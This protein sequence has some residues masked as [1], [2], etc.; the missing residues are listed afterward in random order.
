ML[1]L[2]KD[3]LSQRVEPESVNKDISKENESKKVQIATCALFLEVAESDEDFT[4]EEREKIFS[5]MKE[6]FNLEDNYVEELI[7]LSEE[8]RKHSISLYEF[9]DVI[10]KEFT[11]QEKYNVVKNLWHLIFVDEILHHYEDY[12]I[13]KISGNLKLSHKDMIAAKLEAK[14][15]LKK[16]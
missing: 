16:L 3:I 9:T 1:K 13:R 10:N 15:E 12:F 4:D 11:D 5:I 14:D 2:L 7:A 8:H 6:T